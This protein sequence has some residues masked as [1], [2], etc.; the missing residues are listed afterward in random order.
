MKKNGE[1]QGVKK[2]GRNGRKNG[3]KKETKRGRKKEG[4]KE[5]ISRKAIDWSTST[6]MQVNSFGK[7]AENSTYK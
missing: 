7:S 6:M 2:E 3:K 4:T 1:K 5:S